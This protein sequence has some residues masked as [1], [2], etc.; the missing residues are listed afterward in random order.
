M[1]QPAGI[2]PL[3]S[4]EYETVTEVSS[5]RMPSPEGSDLQTKSVV[6]SRQMP[7]DSAEQT[8]AESVQSVSVGLASTVQREPAGLTVTQVKVFS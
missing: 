2:S 7:P 8:G 3:V 6:V 1:M 4:F 5:M